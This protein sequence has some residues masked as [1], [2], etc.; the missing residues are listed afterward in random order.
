MCMLFQDDVPIDLA[1]HVSNLNMKIC[2]GRQNDL[3]PPNTQLTRHRNGVVQGSFLGGNGP[4]R[5]LSLLLSSAR[6]LLWSL[7]H[8]RN[9][10]PSNPKQFNASA[11]KKQ[12]T[13]STLD[14]SL[15]CQTTF[16]LNTAAPHWWGNVANS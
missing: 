6:P 4:R 10:I 13:L 14:R 12:G 9:S 7:S 16:F 3:P 1:Y 2:S 15:W 11:S 5:V 8:R